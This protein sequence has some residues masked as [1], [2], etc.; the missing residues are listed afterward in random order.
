MWTVKI[1]N[2]KHLLYLQHAIVQSYTKKAA[3]LF[4]LNYYYSF[5]FKTLPFV[6]YLIIST[7]NEI[8]I[9]KYL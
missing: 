4:F 5:I 6:K 3:L 1:S 8:L 2:I 7:Y 9:I